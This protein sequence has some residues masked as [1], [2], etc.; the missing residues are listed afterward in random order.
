[1]SCLTWLSSTPATGLGA[2]FARGCWQMF[3]ISNEQNFTAMN[4]HLTPVRQPCPPSFHVFLSITLFVP[5]RLQSCFAYIHYWS[6]GNAHKPIYFLNYKYL[7]N[8]LWF[9][10]SHSRVLPANP[11]TQLIW[12]DNLWQWYWHVPC[13][14]SRHCL[15]K[16][17]RK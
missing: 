11:I 12:Q 2:K 5:Q 4:L 16:A 10:R 17:D 14:Y 6:A 3:H 1:M 8:Y 13:K 9:I 15:R 7:M